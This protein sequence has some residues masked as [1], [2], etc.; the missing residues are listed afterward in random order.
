MCSLEPESSQSPV[1]GSPPGIVSDTESWSAVRL[2]VA[3]MF[4]RILE[5][6]NE[7]EHNLVLYLLLHTQ[8]NQ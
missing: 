1:E 4:Q 8:G 6:E 2:H 3:V 7:S 5:P